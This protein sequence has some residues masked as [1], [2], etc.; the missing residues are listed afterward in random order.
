MLWHWHQPDRHARDDAQIRLEEEAVERGTAAP[1]VYRSS[2]A[3]GKAAEARLDTLARR[4]HNLE[5]TGERGMFA[6][7]RVAEAA[8]ERVADNAAIGTRAGGIHPQAGT[9]RPKKLVQL[10]LRNTGLDRDVRQR[11]A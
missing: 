7:W 4:Q 2:L 6:I 11:L 8:L 3:V 1:F 10:P 5:A 9:L